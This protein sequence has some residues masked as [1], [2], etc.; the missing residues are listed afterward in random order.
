MSAFTKG[1][2]KYVPW[3]VEEGPPAVR[4]PE[5]WLVC[6]TSSDADAK[7]IA[8]AP[9]LLDAAESAAAILNELTEPDM[10]VSA[11]NIYFRARALEA[12]IRAIIARAT[13]QGEMK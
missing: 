7:L 11:G 5:G 4:A 3:H 9:C 1:P 10:S 13:D 2:W 6:T 8:I 12:D